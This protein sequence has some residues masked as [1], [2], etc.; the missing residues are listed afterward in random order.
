MGEGGWRFDVVG[1]RQHAEK[2]R[3]EYFDEDAINAKECEIAYNATLMALLWDA[4]A[5]KNA[6][7]LPF[8]E[9]PKTGDARFSGSLASLVGLE[10]A[11]QAHDAQAIDL[12]IQT[13]NTL[14]AVILLFGGIPLMYYGNA[15]GMLNDVVYL[16]DPDK[17]DD[18]RWVHRYDFDWDEAAKRKQPGTVE[19][20]IFCAIKKLIAV[21]KALFAFADFDNR[22]LLSVSNPNLLVYLRTEPKMHQNKVLVV[23]NFNTEPQ[24]LQMDDLGS[25]ILFPR[26]IATDL[27]TVTDLQLTDRS[28][29]V[30]ARGFLWLKE[31]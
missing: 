30:P 27:V 6:R 26:H 4:V 18:N 7:G 20:R 28:I 8:G 16:A 24:T 3:A 31:A 13:I 12:A 15:T 29:T 5:T 2:Q 23:A 22:Q 10:A 19:N 17:A 21:R 1:L 11:M 14:H 25:A 9:N